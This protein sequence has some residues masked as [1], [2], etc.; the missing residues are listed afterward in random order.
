MTTYKSK[1]GPEL[2]IPLSLLLGGEGALMIY[3]RSWPGLLIIIVVSLFIAHLFLTTYYQIDG[4]TL[5]IRSG[6]LL[7]KSLDISAIR[8]IEETRNPQS[9]PAISLDRLEIWYNKFDSVLVSPKDKIG[10]IRELTA[11]NPAIDVRLKSHNWE[12]VYQR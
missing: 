2:A 1:I 8:K 4:R 7:N 12:G 11:L 10:F 9:S 5:T 6:F 3:N